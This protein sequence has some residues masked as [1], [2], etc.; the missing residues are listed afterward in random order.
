MQAASDTLSMRGF[1]A[2][3]LVSICSVALAQPVRLDV[4]WLRNFDNQDALALAQ[5]PRLEQR[6][7][8]AQVAGTSFD[9][10]DSWFTELRLR[11]VSLGTT[12]GLAVRASHLLCGG[13]G[14]CQTWILRRAKG[15]WVNTFAGEAP[16]ATSVGFVRHTGSVRDV[17]VSTNDGAPSALWTRY[18][19]DGRWYRRTKC[20]RVAPDTAAPNL[21]ETPCGR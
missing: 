13:T 9:T 14:N 20:Y 8:I 10:P 21:D 11:R 2:A 5:F 6:Q 3:C 1:V 15:Q 19:F 16:I 4:E 12:D 18:R 7:I 17:V